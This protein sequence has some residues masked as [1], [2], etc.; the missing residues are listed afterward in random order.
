MSQPAPTA[1]ATVTPAKPTQPKISPARTHTV[2]AGETLAAV[3]RKHN[4]SL[5]ALQ[6]AN[7]G[8]SPKKMRVGQSL[9]LPPP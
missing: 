2:L 1:T 7:P 6:A 8:V 4:V 9:N 3:A 5:T